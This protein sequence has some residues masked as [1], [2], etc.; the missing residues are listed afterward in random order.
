MITFGRIGR[1]VSTVEFNNGT[2]DQIGTP[3]PEVKN[4]TNDLGIPCY[5]KSKSIPIS[6]LV[7]ILRIKPNRQNWNIKFR[8]Y[9]ALN[10]YCGV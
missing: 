1:K 5:A 8:L 9:W 2:E 6:V 10:Q 3:S 7:S 4:N